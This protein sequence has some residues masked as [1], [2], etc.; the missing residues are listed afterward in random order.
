MKFVPTPVAGAF[1]I[2]SEPTT[3]ERGGFM[4]TWCAREAEEHGLCLAVAQ[5]SISMNR[6]KG[7]LRGMHYQTAPA[8]ETKVVRCLRGSIFDVIVDLRRGSSSFRR[9]FGAELSRDNHRAMYVPRGVAH[10]FL[11]LEDDCDVH[12]QISALH[13]P[14]A[15]RG[16]RWNDPL[17]GVVWPGEVRVISERDRTYPDCQV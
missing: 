9:W 5:C 1:V 12:Y 15:A 7:T 10:G 6:A 3:D 8:E 13:E 17:F 14:A 2:E 4:R 11:T 16:F